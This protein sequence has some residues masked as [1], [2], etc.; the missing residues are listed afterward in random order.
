MPSD[1]IVTALTSGG[2]GVI[3]TDTTYGIVGSAFTRG[4]VERIYKLRRRD[5]DKPFIILI[6]DRK[7]LGRF[8]VV[9]TKAEK[10]IL[11][12]VWPG[13]VSVILPCADPTLAYLHRGKNTLAFRL[14]A[15]IDLTEL[16]SKTGPLVA[17]SANPQG[18][19]VA[20]TIA[21]ARTYFGNEMDFYQ[22]GG[23]IIAPPSRLIEIWNGV[24]KVLRD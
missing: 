20:T 9:T 19:P 13:A 16:L 3:P 10:K 8:G 11:D 24:E 18:M 5:S 12:H 7:D 2:V 14:P 4:A 23:T 6:G 21:E 22:D 15:K 1:K 17:P